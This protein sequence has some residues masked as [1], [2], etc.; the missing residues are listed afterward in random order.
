LYQQLI[1]KNKKLAV[2]GLGYVGLPIALEFAKKVKVIGFDIN[3]KRVEMMRNNIDPSRE[4]EA[5]AFEGCDIE[6]TNDLEVLKQAGFF[7]VAVPTPVDEHNV[8]DL[9][10]VKRAS[11]TIG[12]VI[13]KGDYV[14]FE[15]TVY[16]GCT[17]E[18][19]LPIIEKLSGLKNINDFKSGYSPER[20]NP[21]DKEHTLA[22]IIKVVSGCDAESLELIAKVYELVVTAGVHKASSIKVAEAAKIIENTQRD[23]NIALMNELSIIFDRMGINTFEVL[24]AAGTKWNFLKFQPGLVGGHCIGVDPYYLTYKSKELG[25]DSQVILAGR[26]INDGMAEYIAKKVLQHIIQNNGNVKDAKVLV[27]GATFKENVSDIRNSKV[28]DVVKELQSFSLNVHITDPHADS[29]ELQ[30]EYGFGLTADTASD[31]DAVIITVPHNN[32]K[33]LDDVYFAGIT[34]N[35]AIIADLKGIYRGKINSRQYWSL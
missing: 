20:I 14:V 22:K 18:D 11:E 21:G 26:V 34:K 28:A 31:Y 17:E 9:V 4:L 27:M 13:K 16:P 1:N 25:Y 29:A 3:A 15:S 24:E 33:K 6:F 5:S 7:I 32:Y 30:H 19:C 12:K 2:I 35:K 8:P 10:P 23:I